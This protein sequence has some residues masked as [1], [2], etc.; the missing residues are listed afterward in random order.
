MYKLHKQPKEMIPQ[1][2]GR[3]TNQLQPEDVAA[4]WVGRAELLRAKEGVFT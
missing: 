3:S 2:P 1:E 4:G